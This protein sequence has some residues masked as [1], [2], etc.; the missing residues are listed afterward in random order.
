[1]LNYPRWKLYLVII[2]LISAIFVSLPNFFKKGSF[3]IFGKSTQRVNFGL[4]L[5]GGAYILLQIDNEGYLADKVQSLQDEVVEIFRSNNICLVFTTAV[6]R[7]GLIQPPLDTP[8]PALM[9]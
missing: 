5:Q 3:E 8:Q 2:F 4:D 1:M 7:R 6:A 9:R